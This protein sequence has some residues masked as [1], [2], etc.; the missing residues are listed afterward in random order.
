MFKPWSPSSISAIGV[1]LQFANRKIILSH[2]Y[3]FF[4]A[5]LYILLT[6]CLTNTISEN[7][8]NTRIVKTK[9]GNLRGFYI[10]LPNKMLQPVETFLGK[11]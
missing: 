7:R 6:Q 2:Q 5:F 3:N 8:L 11:L 9:Y 10:N 1:L 4:Y